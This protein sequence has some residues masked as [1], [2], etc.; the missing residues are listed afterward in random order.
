M[1]P[2]AYM[3]KDGKW[4]Y[5]GEVMAQAGTEKTHY[6]GDRFFP[7]GEYDYVFDVDVGDDAPKA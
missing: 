5:V 6:H 4:D 7:K 2:K 3:W 1:V